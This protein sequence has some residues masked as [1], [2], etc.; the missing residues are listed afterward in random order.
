MR[1]DLALAL[2]WFM[3]TIFSANVNENTRIPDNRVRKAMI[4]SFVSPYS[5]LKNIS[6]YDITVDLASRP[7]ADE[8]GRGAI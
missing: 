2:D 1:S 3:T 4:R 8:M 5:Y 6:G 7:P